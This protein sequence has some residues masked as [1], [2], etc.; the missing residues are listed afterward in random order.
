M[1]WRGVRGKWPN[2]HSVLGGVISTNESI[3]GQ[4]KSPFLLR[5]QHPHTQPA[6][7]EAE[8]GC[9]NEK[10]C[11]EMTAC[12]IDDVA[13]LKGSFGSLSSSIG[14]DA[15]ERRVQCSANTHETREFP[16]L[17]FRPQ[18]SHRQQ[19]QKHSHI[20]S[21]LPLSIHHICKQEDRRRAAQ[22]NGRKSDE[23]HLLSAAAARWK[24][25]DLSK[26]VKIPRFNEIISKRGN[27]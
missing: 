14:N 26:V 7:P 10:E 4:V 20:R 12:V 2:I 23:H 18:F 11:G 15:D 21:A 13:T 24:W 27:M 6:E 3:F 19:S 5:Q 22:L 25:I 17:L 9:Q 16:P 8:A 1:A